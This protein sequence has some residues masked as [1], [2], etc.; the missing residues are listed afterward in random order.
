MDSIR[1]ILPAHLG[2]MMDYSLVTT[3]VTPTSCFLLFLVVFILCRLI[4][5]PKYPPGPMALPV[6]GNYKLLTDPKIHEA[7]ARLSEKYG[8]VVTVQFGPSKTVVLNSI[9]TVVEAM[10][11]RRADFAGRPPVPSGMTLSEGGKDILMSQYTPSLKVHRKIVSAAL[12]KYIKGPFLQTI[13]EKSMGQFIKLFEETK[14][15][16]FIPHEYIDLALF[17]IICGVCFQKV[18]KFDDPKFKHYLDIDNQFVAEFG[19]GLIEDLY[20]I[21]AKVWQSQRYKK[22]VSLFRELLHYIHEELE[23]HKQDFDEGNIRDFAD[24]LLMARKEA[25]NEEDVEILSQLTD[26][27]LRQTLSDTFTAAF[28]TT[29]FTIQWALL[30]MADH[31]DV[32]RKVQA[33]LDRVVGRDRLPRVDDRPSLPY[34]EATLFEVMRI[35]SVAPLGMPHMTMVDSSVGGYTVPKGTTVIINH[36]ALH[37]DPRHWKEPSKLD[38]ERFLN[39]DGTLARKPES[40]LPFSAGLRVCLGESTAKPELV[41]IL[42]LILHQFNI[43]LPPGVKADYSPECTGFIGYTAN[44]YKVIAE[45]RC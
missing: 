17:N 25:E 5:K 21:L 2:N 16:P 9:E 19:M 8:P 33:E 20:P 42:A 23:A 11:K 30:Y 1:H 13:L 29:R 32:Q 27:H 15:N 26:V 24:C 34:T 31:Q 6:I 43:K 44:R 4:T 39:S 3:S 7:C 45:K 10:V 12:R 28:D 40:F 35:A 41:I 22:V 36:W 18:Y 37:N 14:G 38:P